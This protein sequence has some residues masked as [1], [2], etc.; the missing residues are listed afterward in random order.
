MRTI[1]L[2]IDRTDLKEN[3]GV[4]LRVYESSS[5]GDMALQHSL[6]VM[7]DQEIKMVINDRQ[8][9]ELRSVSRYD[10]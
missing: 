8:A 5:M 4:A 1:T 6:E 3:E 2:K 9:V 7:D 10:G